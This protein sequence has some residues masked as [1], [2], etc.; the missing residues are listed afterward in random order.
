MTGNSVESV[1]VRVRSSRYGRYSDEFRQEAVRLVRESGLSKA[2]V[3][4][5]LGI[6]KMTLD[7]WI[8]KSVL[9][10]TD[11]AAGSVQEGFDLHKEFLA[12]KKLIKEQQEVIDILKK[13]HRYWVKENTI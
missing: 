6:A 3:A 4:K 10:D 2:R 7:S 13:A 12:Q 8:A 11:S 1:G 5:D 9:A